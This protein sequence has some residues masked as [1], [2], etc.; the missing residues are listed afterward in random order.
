[1]GNVKPVDDPDETGETAALIA[2]E[3]ALP[4]DEITFAVLLPFETNTATIATT[5]MSVMTA[6][7]F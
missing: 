4:A 3:R 2:P 7:I 5:T 6:T 1:M